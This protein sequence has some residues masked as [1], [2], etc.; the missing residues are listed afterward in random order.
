MEPDGRPALGRGV[1]RDRAVSTR[2][3]DPYLREGL[4]AGHTCL[5][6]AGEGK[7]DTI[8]ETLVGLDPGLS[9]DRLEVTQPSDAHLCT[10]TFDR[11]PCCT[12][13]TSGPRD[14]FERD[15]VI[16]DMSC[17]P[18]L[19]DLTGYETRATRWAAGA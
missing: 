10:G 3:L 6:L 7:R 14:V 9:L 15:G 12:R 2:L 18:F 19:N 11:T 16:A 5:C 13:S 1:A 4:S 8:S 17:A